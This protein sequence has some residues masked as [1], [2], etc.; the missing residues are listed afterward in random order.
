MS[1]KLNHL[2]FQK[3]EKIHITNRYVKFTSIA[4]GCY[5]DRWSGT[6]AKRNW[7]YLGKTHV[8]FTGIYPIK[9]IFIGLLIVNVCN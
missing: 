6:F 7:L 1:Y 4:K 9:K 8:L 3:F 2:P 5:K